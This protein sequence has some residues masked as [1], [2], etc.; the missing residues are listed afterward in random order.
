M[1]WIRDPVEFVLYKINPPPSSRPIPHKMRDGHWQ[2]YV[3]GAVSLEHFV[4]KLLHVTITQD[5]NIEF[6]PRAIQPRN[7]LDGQKTLQ[8]F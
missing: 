2:D 6:L 1:A 3:P 5:I 7:L 8:A 4:N